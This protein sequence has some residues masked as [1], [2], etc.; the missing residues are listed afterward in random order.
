MRGRPDEDRQQPVGVL[1]AQPR[2][3]VGLG[4]LPHRA[5][6]HNRGAPGGEVLGEIDS[7]IHGR[8]ERERALLGVAV[9][10]VVDVVEREAVQPQRL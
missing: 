8:Q 10:L 3:E 6:D 9:A 1:G 7:R 5:E 2:P 4:V